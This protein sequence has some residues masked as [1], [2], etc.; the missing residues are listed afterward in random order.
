M[1]FLGSKY[2]KIAFVAGARSART[3]LTGPFRNIAIPCGT[4]KKTRMVGL[5]NCNLFRVAYVQ[6][7]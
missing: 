6:R 5:P 7:C 3:P 2:A 1:L 4:K